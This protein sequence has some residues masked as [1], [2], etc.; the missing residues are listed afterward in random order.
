MQRYKVGE[1]MFAQVNGKP[2]RGKLESC[3]MIKGE[4]YYHIEGIVFGEKEL[5][6]NLT[7]LVSKILED[8]NGQSTRSTGQGNPSTFKEY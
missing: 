2:I 8:L 6:E 3:Y 4:F 5:H 7:S 1:T